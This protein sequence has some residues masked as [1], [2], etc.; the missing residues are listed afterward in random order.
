MVGT[1][2]GVPLID[3]LAVGGLG[4]SGVVGADAGSEPDV[5][6]TGDAARGLGVAYRS[7]K[8]GQKWH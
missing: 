1:R 6:A 2:Q 4:R 5:E 3:R 8:H 7:S